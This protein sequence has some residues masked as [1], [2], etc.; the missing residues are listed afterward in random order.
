MT[1]NSGWAKGQVKL[2]LFSDEFN[3]DL[4]RL[5]KMGTIRESA[6]EYESKETKNISELAE[7]STELDLKTK[8]VELEDGD[9][10]SYDYIEVTGEEYRVP[11]TVLKQLKAMI[12][13]NP[14][15]LK[16]K[17]LKKGEGLKTSYTT[18]AL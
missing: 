4:W 2:E 17:V 1:L 5:N 11:K 15:I 3:P 13:D 7:V 9:S 16:F 14:N 12:D 8:K 10:F 6:R 18:I